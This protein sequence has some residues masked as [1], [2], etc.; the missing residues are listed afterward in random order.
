M[1]NRTY[2]AR[3]LVGAPSIIS[4]EMDEHFV[5]AFISIQFFTSDSYSEADQ[6]IPSSGTLDI[7]ASEQ[8]VS[9]GTIPNG[10]AIDVTDQDY[11]RINFLGSVRY[12]KGVGTAISGSGATHYQIKITRR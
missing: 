2:Y 10:S 6:V 7:T 12:V 8:G 5:E 3:G 1:R 11:P 9:Y 4:N